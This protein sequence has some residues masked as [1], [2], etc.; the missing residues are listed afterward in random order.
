MMRIRVT[1]FLLI[2]CGCGR[3]G[4][5]SQ[6]LETAALASWHI[7][8]APLVTIGADDRLEGQAFG[9]VAG[10]LRLDNGSIVVADVSPPE[11]RLFDSTGRY[12]RTLGRSGSGPGEFKWL[13]PPG[14]FAGDS[15][16]VVDV[17]QRRAS[18]YD[19]EGRPAGT[20]RFSIQ[21]TDGRVFSPI[22]MV[23]SDRYIAAL[24]E[25]KRPTRLGQ[26]IRNAVELVTG[27]FGA[28]NFAAIARSGGN[29]VVGGIWN[30][31]GHQSVAA[32][33]VEFGNRTLVGVLGSRIFLGES[34]KPAVTEYEIGGR[35]KG[36]ITWEALPDS[37]TEKDRNARI[38]QESTRISALPQGPDPGQR[39]SEVEQL[40]AAQL[41]KYGPAFTAILPAG[42]GSLWIERDPRPWTP[43]YDFLVFDTLRTIV[44]RI[45]IPRQL[46]VF[47]V[48]ADFVLARWRDPGEADQVRLYRI[49]R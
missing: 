32:Y 47:Q 34:S 46:K 19:N 21:L 39:W 24:L 8:D 28:A 16:F 45:A 7:A 25:A 35:V 27:Q 6:T 17:A 9:R 49:L 4:T 36:R 3:T 26:H 23:S 20:R 5:K 31:G 40:R 14:F 12:L 15:F 1:L 18:F 33:P 44:A 13:G 22:G 2:T 41:P 10:A 38:T 42:D 11:L 37:I 29:E 30:E 48:G 43:S